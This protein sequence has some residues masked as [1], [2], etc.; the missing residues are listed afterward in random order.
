M[1]VKI[2][3]DI[4]VFLS[5]IDPD[6]SVAGFKIASVVFGIAKEK[7]HLF[8]IFHNKTSQN[9]YQYS[10]SQCGRVPDPNVI[11]AKVTT[12]GSIVDP[13]W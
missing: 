2:P 4:F 11:P 3:E 6:D 9:K 7:F 5:P 8:Q 10:A 13:L 12:R 1:I